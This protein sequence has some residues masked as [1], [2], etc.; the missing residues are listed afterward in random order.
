[1]E[2]EMAREVEELREKLKEAALKLKEALLASSPDIPEELVQGETVEEV[3][4]SFRRAKEIVG[5]VREKLEMERAREK[6]PSGSPGRTGID[7]YSLS[8]KEKIIYGLT[9]RG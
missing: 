1:M 2:E 9:K 8:P 5:K 6:I 3:E 4:E 7:I